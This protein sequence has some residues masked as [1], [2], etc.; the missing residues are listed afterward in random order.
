[1]KFSFLAVIGLTYSLNI[2]ALS[3]NDLENFYICNPTQKTQAESEAGDFLF[4]DARLQIEKKNSKFMQ[5]IAPTSEVITNTIGVINESKNSLT[6]SSFLIA[7][8]RGETGRLGGVFEQSVSITQSRGRTIILTYSA[9]AKLAVFK[10]EESYLCRVATA[11]QIN[12]F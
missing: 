10:K 5:M 7:G 4:R 6:F 3:I 2:F 11:E 8:Q 9:D 12:S 1:M